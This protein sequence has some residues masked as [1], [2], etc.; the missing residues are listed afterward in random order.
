[1]AKKFFLYK[2]CFIISG[3]KNTIICDTYENRFIN[4][5]EKLQFDI[6]EKSI[7]ISNDSQNFI[8]YLSEEGYGSYLFD[9][10]VIDKNII[11]SSPRI[12]DEIIVLYSELLFQ[13]ID[14]FISFI[15]S[16]NAQYLQIRFNSNFNDINKLKSFLLSLSSSPIKTIEILLDSQN[17]LESDVIEVAIKHTRVQVIFFYNSSF[18]SSKTLEKELLTV[19]NV[20]NNILDS[21]YCGIIDENY[22]LSD[23]KYFSK[24]HFHNNCLKGKIFFDEKMNAFNCPSF[25]QSFGNLM[26]LNKDNLAGNAFFLKY[27]NITKNNIKVCKDCEFRYIC[28]DCRAYTEQT[29]YNEEGLDVSKPLKCGYNP[30]TGEWEKWSTNPIKQKA[31]K[32]YGMQKIL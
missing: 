22:F 17:F 7:I 21:K 4:I 3:F 20:K 27:Q 30:Y 28:T 26:N 23:L 31:I 18:N 32:N 25:S 12:V 9:E 13:N 19:V 11:W 6:I 15:V 24:S 2:D 14:S 29:Y 5:P 8:S 1:M 16:V 10:N